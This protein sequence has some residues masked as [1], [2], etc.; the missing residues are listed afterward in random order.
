MTEAV[1]GLQPTAAALPAPTLPERAF[2]PDQ[3]RPGRPRPRHRILRRLA[4]APGVALVAALAAA[5]A[6]AFASH[7]DLL[8]L[9]ADARSHLTI[10]RR[11]P[12]G[13]PPAA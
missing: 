3:E 5:L 4:G 6:A 2:W 8:L 13:N 7:H 10:A 12:G 9:Y 11:Q 1:W